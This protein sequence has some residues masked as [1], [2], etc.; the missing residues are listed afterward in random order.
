MYSTYRS[1]IFIESS[2]PKFEARNPKQIQNSNDRNARRPLFFFC[3]WCLFRISKFEF[4]IFSSSLPLHL[5]SKRHRQR[6]D[7]GVAAPD[8]GQA[9]FQRVLEVLKLPRD[10][11]T[12]VLA[13]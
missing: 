9:E 10:V 12:G 8:Q 13:G 5:P 2:N 7:G 11:F 6:E 3:H 4:R 1:R